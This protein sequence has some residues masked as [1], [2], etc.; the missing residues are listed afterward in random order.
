MNAMLEYSPHQAMMHAA[1]VSAAASPGGKHFISAPRRFGKTYAAVI[2]A[3]EEARRGRKVTLLG[4]SARHAKNMAAAATDLCY[5]EALP[6]TLRCLDPSVSGWKD[7]E[8]LVLDEAS[9][10]DVEVM[11][12][13]HELPA[14]VIFTGTPVGAG[15]FDEH[16]SNGGDCVTV[17]GFVA[18][19]AAETKW[20]A[21]ERSKA[22]QSELSRFSWDADHD[23]RA[24][25]MK[26][27]DRVGK[28]E[29]AAA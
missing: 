5:P 3:L 21:R 7:A 20:Q 13:A 24:A 22:E 29:Q 6:P 11:R 16:V 12:D 18:S 27:Y 14:S 4:V 2:W 1:M 17:I 10:A 26:L 19:G 25:L 15:H 28:L 23:V 9:R 8:V